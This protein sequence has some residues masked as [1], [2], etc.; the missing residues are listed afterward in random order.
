MS[1]YVV[2]RLIRYSGISS[3]DKHAAT[4]CVCARNTCLRVRREVWLVISCPLHCDVVTQTVN[5]SA[6]L[7]VQTG[8]DSVYRFRCPFA[9]SL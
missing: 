9:R 6:L 5:W 1:H 3:A 7:Y 2:S 4:Q 8:L